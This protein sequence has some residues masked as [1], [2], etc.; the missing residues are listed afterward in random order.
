[1][2]SDTTPKVAPQTDGARPEPTSIT[3]S[4]LLS[5]AA[6]FDDRLRILEGALGLPPS[7]VLPG[8]NQSPEAIIPSLAHLSFQLSSLAS[9]LTGSLPSTATS[10]PPIDSLAVK[11]RALTT[12]AD[13]LT[14]AR[15]RATAAALAA[16]AARDRDDESDIMTEDGKPITEIGADDPKAKINALYASLPTITSLHPL[17]PTVLERLRS[18]RTVHVRAAEARMDLEEVERR[19]GLM[20][21]EIG[22]W[23]EG[24]EAVEGKMREGEGVMKANVQVVGAWVKELEHRMGKF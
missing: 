11:I 12:D 20:R 22:R 16:A 15:K 3:S 23:R 21:E 8:T 4:S 2:S 9:T 18:L 6:S 7:T 1:M 14:S 19:Q 5:Q 13:K 10:T 17:L 24:L